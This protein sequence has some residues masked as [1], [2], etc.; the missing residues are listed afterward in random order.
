MFV[1]GVRK[2]N[3]YVYDRYG[4]L[5]FETDKIDRTWDGTNKGKLLP[6]GNYSYKCLMVRE[7]D[8]VEFTKFGSIKLIR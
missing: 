7:N 4:N 3:L 5:V 1:N 6:Q 8:I 2:F